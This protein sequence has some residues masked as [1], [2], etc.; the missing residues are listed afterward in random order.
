MDIK[1]AS[2]KVRK[3]E[4]LFLL[5]ALPSPSSPSLGVAATTSWANAEVPTLSLLNTQSSLNI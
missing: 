4:H 1:G 5:F 3:M 2:R